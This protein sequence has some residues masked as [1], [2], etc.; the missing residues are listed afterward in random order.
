MRSNAITS[1]A[2]LSLLAIPVAGIAAP[3]RAPQVPVSGTAL[4]SFFAAKG[5]SISV[6]GDQRDVQVVRLEP[7]TTIT[8]RDAAGAATFGGYNALFASPPL[9]QVFP[10]AA[11][12]GWFCSAAFRSAPT[13]LVVNVFDSN[14]AFQGS[15]TYLAGPP[16][17]AAFGFYASGA[18]TVYSQDS[19]NG[20]LA[21][22]LAYEGTGPNVGSL[23]F[24]CELSND[25]VGDFADLVMLLTFSSAP[26]GTQRSTWGRLQQL[27]R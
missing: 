4:A 16:D 3:L 14:D 25:P 20:G 6:V 12:S 27:Y 18:A 21:R 19:R 26:V 24:A 23:W 17:P 13:R 5:Q 9:Y 8:L 22:I 10:G 11:S 15:T 2:L 1:L 7:T